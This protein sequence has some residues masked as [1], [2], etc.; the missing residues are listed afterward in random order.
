MVIHICGQ[1]LRDAMSTAVEIAQS[2]ERQERA[3]V[4]SVKLAAI[5]SPNA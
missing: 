5:A 1:N 2:L 4:F 3:R